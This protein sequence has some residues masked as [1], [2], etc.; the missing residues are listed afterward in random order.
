MHGL[1]AAPDQLRGR[2]DAMAAS[3]AAVRQG[4]PVTVSQQTG[5]RKPPE[6][7]SAPLLTTAR[8]QVLL[9]AATVA[10]LG[11][12]CPDECLLTPCG[13]AASIAWED[14]QWDDWGDGDEEEQESGPAAV[15][16]AFAGNAPGDWHVSLSQGSPVERG[17][18]FGKGWSPSGHRLASLH[19]RGQDHH[20]AGQLYDTQE[21]RW[22]QEV[23]VHTAPRSS[24]YNSR[25]EFSVCEAFAAAA[26]LE[27]SLSGTCSYFIGVFGASP[28]PARVLPLT[29]QWHAFAWLPCGSLIVWCCGSLARVELLTGACASASIILPH[30][31]RVSRQWEPIDEDCL[32]VLPSGQAF[33]VLVLCGIVVTDECNEAHFELTLFEAAVL[34]GLSLQQLQLT[35]PAGMEGSEMLLSLQA[36]QHAV[37]VSWRGWGTFLYRIEG[38]TVLAGL[39]CMLDHLQHPSFDASGQ[40]LAGIVADELWVVDGRTG[41]SLA[42]IRRSQLPPTQA[43]ASLQVN[44]VCWDVQHRPQLHIAATVSGLVPHA[45]VSF[46]TLSF[47]V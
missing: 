34:R 39:M 46:V 12:L 1:R 36:S 11:Q 38:S 20:L 6:P 21:R 25:A 26:Y 42:Q 15:Q 44:S 33:V 10:A 31:V 47:Q 2:L 27:Q 43:E 17:G 24:V 32:A 29:G 28:A 37:A 22:L 45:G 9:P 16:L 7:C 40:L 8:L 35:V 19:K 30:W 18:L 23:V 14:V 5:P 13:T 3:L 41:A 4:A